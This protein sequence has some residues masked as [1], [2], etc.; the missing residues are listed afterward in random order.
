[1]WFSPSAYSPKPYPITR[2]LIEEGRNHIL[3]GG[4]IRTY[5]PV[6][7][8]QGMQDDDVPWRHS[9]ALVEHLASDPVT[10]TLVKDGDHR[11]SR[12]EDLTRL[13]AAIEGMG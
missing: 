6:H 1:V 12:D 5:C 11:L 8:L 3:F 13:T 10:L 7:I 9:M 4:E 2:R